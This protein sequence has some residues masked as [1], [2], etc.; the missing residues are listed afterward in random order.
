M[1]CLKMKSLAKFK[2]KIIK[3]ERK[4]SSEKNKQQYKR[5]WA[6]HIILWIEFNF[7]YCF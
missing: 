7:V 6:P 5:N 3:T 1:S 4:E 2:K